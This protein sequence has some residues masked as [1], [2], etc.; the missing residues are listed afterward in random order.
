MAFLNWLAS[1]EGIINQLW[2]FTITATAVLYVICNVLPD[3][4][5][6]RILPLHAVFKPKTNVDLDFQ[7]IGYALLHTTW[8]TKITHATILIEAMLWFVIFQSWHWSIPFL[9]LAVMLVQSLFIGDLRFGSCFMLVGIATCAGAA[10]TIDRLGMRHAVLLA[11]VVLML[12]GLLRMLS[13]SAELIPPLLVNNSDQF[14]KLSSRNINWKVPLSSIVGYVGEFGSS[15][16]NRI[17]P[18]QVNYLYQTLFRVKPQTTLSWPEIDTAAKT[19]LVGGYSKLKS[20][21]TYY[22]SVTGGK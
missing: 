19:V 1:Y 18:V 16:P 11:E 20:L 6:G 14:E 13:H 3:R 2:L 17:L 5:V 7:S 21:Q 9:V 12:G 4:I 15:L 8:V 22:N 10:Y